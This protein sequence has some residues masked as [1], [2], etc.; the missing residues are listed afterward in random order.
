MREAEK[1]NGNPK[2]EQPSAVDTENQRRK[3]AR[4]QE[5]AIQKARRL[6]FLCFFKILVFE[7]R[8]FNRYCYIKDYKIIYLC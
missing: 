5:V 7:L 3:L 2:G 4:K 8:F 6:I 1:G